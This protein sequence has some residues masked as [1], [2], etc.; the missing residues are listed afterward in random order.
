MSLR[1]R[2]ASKREK[3]SMPSGEDFLG[4]LPDAVIQYVLSFLPSDEVVRTC[5][6]S[7]RWGDLW[8]TIHALSITH[9]EDKWK[10][11]EDMNEFVNHLLLLRDRSPL[12]VCEINSYPDCISD[13]VDKPFR[14][15]DLWIRYAL[16]LKAQVLRVLIYTETDHM[17]L[18]APLISQHLTVLELKMVELGKGA[19]DF[20]SCPVLKAL[21]ML[22]CVIRARKISFQSLRHLIATD[23]VFD[24]DSR[25][26]ISA[27]SLVSLQLHVFC[28][29]AP[30]L[31]NMPLLVTASINL[32]AECH[33]SCN[34]W[35]SGDCGY[36]GCQGCHDN[37]DGSDKCVLLRGL[38]NATSL[39]LLVEPDVFILKRDLNLCP[40]FGK[41]KTL[42]LNEWSLAGDLHSLVCLL[43][44]SPVLE[45]LTFQLHEVPEHL[46]EMKEN[47]NPKEQPH[48]YEHLKIV[49]VKCREVGDDR[50]HKF[51]KC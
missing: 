43:Q 50:I 12:D 42:L 38:S 24:E 23:M 30:V 14:Y 4:S 33:D 48:A 25:T 8:K 15:I 2:K 16:S 40:T 44:H 1:R 37:T 26:R 27:P 7:R 51:L 11:A 39:E 32:D 21:R 29:R 49:V 5:V 31:Q 28:G 6:L 35:S 19:L 20:S 34:R 13:N 9:T 17:E 3:A 10:N 41:L 18:D 36:D 22:N 45:K 47:Q 46:M